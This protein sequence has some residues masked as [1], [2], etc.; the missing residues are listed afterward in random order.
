MLFLGWRTR[1]WARWRCSGDSSSRR[2]RMVAGR[3]LLGGPQGCVRI[4]PHCARSGASSPPCGRLHATWL[5]LHAHC[6]SSSRLVACRAWGEGEAVKHVCVATPTLGG[7]ARTR[8]PRLCLWI[9][10]A[11]ALV[12]PPRPSAPSMSAR[13]RGGVSLCR[14]GKAAVLAACTTA[15]QCTEQCGRRASG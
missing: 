6:R 14:A 8:A 12:R 1:K 10:A 13:V 3:P 4:R 11:G 15:T 2:R 5:M 9:D 7:R